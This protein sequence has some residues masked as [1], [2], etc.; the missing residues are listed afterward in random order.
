[1]RSNSCRSGKYRC[2]DGFISV[3][4]DDPK[5]KAASMGGFFNR[6]VRTLDCRQFLFQ[7]FDLGATSH[8]ATNIFALKLGLG[9]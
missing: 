2:D 7:I 4:T 1:M 8:E 6:M 5:K 9:A 3:R